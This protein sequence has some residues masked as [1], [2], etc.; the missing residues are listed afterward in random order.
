MKKEQVLKLAKIFNIL[1]IIMMII[2]TILDIVIQSIWL[3]DG[4]FSDTMINNFAIVYRV[5]VSILACIFIGSSYIYFRGKKLEI[6]GII[7]LLFA[8]GL[9]FAALLIG[10]NA[11]ILTWILCAISI[12]KLK[13][14]SKIV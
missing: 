10:V 5:Y 11:G 8:S 2:M 3:Q 6:K 1:L 12:Y 7:P 13:Q 4:K 9:T 14:M